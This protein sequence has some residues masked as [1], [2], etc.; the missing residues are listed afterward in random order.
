MYY[1]TVDEVD[2]IDLVKAGAVRQKW[3]DQAQSLNIFVDPENITGSKLNKIY[4]TG[5]KYG[6]KSFYYLRS[7]SPKEKEK[8]Q[9]VMDRSIE[10]AGCQ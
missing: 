8:E 4:I 3:I 5:H 9:V 7:K 1:K 2:M 6:N 10:C